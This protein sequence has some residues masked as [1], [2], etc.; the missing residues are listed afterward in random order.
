[1]AEMLMRAR[2]NITGTFPAFYTETNF[3]DIVPASQ[4][5]QFVHKLQELGMTRGCASTNDAVRR[6][7]PNDPVNRGFVAMVVAQAVLAP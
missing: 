5:S 1:M 4:L 3:A 6:F 7:C 2:Y